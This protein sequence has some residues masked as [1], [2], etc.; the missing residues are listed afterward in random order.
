MHPFIHVFRWDVPLYAVLSFAGAAAMC[1]LAVL[2]AKKRGGVEAEDVFFM[3]LYA[4]IGCIIGAKAL[5]LAVSVKVYWYPDKSFLDNLKYW[6]GL[7][8]QGGLVFY[9]GLAGAFLGALRYLKKYK[10]PVFEHME[11]AVPAVPLFHFFG[12]LGCFMS[13]CCYGIEYDG[14]CA[15]TFE[16]A[17]AAPNGVS[18]FPTQLTEAVFNL[19]LSVALCILYLKKPRRG[20]VAGMYLC[21]YAV[22]RFVLEYFRGDIVR[23]H[24]LSLST[25]QWISLAVLATGI[26]LLFYEKL[27]KRCEKGKKSVG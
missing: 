5:Y 6:Y 20:V 23:G 8:M 9:G 1:V 26:F 16:H 10:L 27:F 14:P 18:L 4:G 11:A 19:L 25:S 12:R 21:C 17:I 22:A 24:M 13:G 15:V 2:I 3:L 7:L